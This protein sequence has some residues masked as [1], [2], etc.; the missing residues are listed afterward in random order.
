MQNTCF[1]VVCLGEVQN[2]N[3]K[4]QENQKNKKNRKT[5]NNRKFRKTRIGGDGHLPIPENQIAAP[6]LD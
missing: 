2:M 6:S 5:K 4:N 3:Q 1:L